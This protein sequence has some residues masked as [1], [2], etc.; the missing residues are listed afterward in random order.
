MVEVSPINKFLNLFVF[1][2]IFMSCS[3]PSIPIISDDKNWSIEVVRGPNDD[4]VDEKGHEI[5]LLF[6][7]MILSKVLVLI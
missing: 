4:W 7:F 1:S 6:V 2:I 3:Q 5:Q